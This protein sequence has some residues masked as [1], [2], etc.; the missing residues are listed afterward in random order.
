MPMITAST[1]LITSTPI[2]SAPPTS[3]ESYQDNSLLV[4]TTPSSMSFDHAIAVN[5][6]P[7]TPQAVSPAALD[8]RPF[9]VVVAIDFGT[10][11]SGYAYSLTREPDSVHIMRKWEGGDPG[12]TNMKTP[13]TLLLTPEGDFHSFG[14]TARD[15]YHDMDHKEAL[16]W[17]YFDKFKLTLHGDP[18]SR[19]KLNVCW[20]PEGFILVLFLLRTRRA[21]KL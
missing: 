21:L 17:L 6:L 9:W 3:D 1:D 12:V 4:S 15:F 13:T 19:H 18:V 14:F 8:T 5:S 10:T 7:A 2:K 11:F 16:R 20:E